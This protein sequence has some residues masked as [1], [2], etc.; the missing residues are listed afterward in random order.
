MDKDKELGGVIYNATPPC[1]GVIKRNKMSR[2]NGYLI[3]G[4]LQLPMAI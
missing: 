4:I 1:I 2:N 3:M